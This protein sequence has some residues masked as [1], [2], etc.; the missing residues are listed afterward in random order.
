MDNWEFV[1]L[2]SYMVL[3]DWTKPQEI[4][5]QIGQVTI[6]CDEHEQSLK[7]FYVSKHFMVAEVKSPWILWKLLW[8]YSSNIPLKI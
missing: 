7:K 6:E 8:E 3:Y 1:S 2:T 5:H 4:M